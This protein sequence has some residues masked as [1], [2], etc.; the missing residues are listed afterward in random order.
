MLYIILKPICI[1]I[2]KIFFGFKVEGKELFPKNK[3]FILA[4]NHLSNLDPVVIGA[5]CPYKLY[6]LA[7]EE[8]FRNKLFAF[9]IKKLN[10]I[11]LSRKK[12]DFGV[13]RLALKI[14]KEKP[15]L[16]F[17]QGTRSFTFNN[18]KAGVGFLYKKTGLPIIVA[19]IY[20]TDKVLP[21]GAR[22]L[23]KGK[24]RVFFDK[25]T[26]LDKDDTVEE[27]AKKVVEKIKS[28]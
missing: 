14:L 5:A 22:F 12:T 16:I 4:S 8:L 15:I 21:K 20:G 2:L 3:P 19:K 24:I 26:Y 27:I 28:L 1:A 25:V 17:P 6:Y 9:L 10:A 13:L 23:K 11:P 18:F 7:K